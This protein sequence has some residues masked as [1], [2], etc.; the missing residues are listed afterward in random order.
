MK[1]ITVLS[2][3]GG[4]GKSSFTASFS[5]IMAN[6]HKV[7]A[8]DCDVDA[9]NLALVLGVEEENFQLMERVQ[10]SE[11]AK[12]IEEKCIQ[13]KECLNAC[14]F[15]SI[16]WDDGKNLPVI[17]KFICT[18]CGACTLACPENALKLESLESASIKVGETE[19]GFPIVSG[20]LDLGESGSGHV[21]NAV[22]I[23]SS[24]L[25]E[26]INAEFILLDS[27]AGIGCPVIASVRGSDYVILVTEPTPAAFWDLKRAID[28]VNHF[29]IPHGVLINRYDINYKF[30]GKIEEY[31]ASN[32]IPVIGKIAYNRK[33]VDALVNLKPVVVFEPKFADVFQEI[34]KRVYL[35]IEF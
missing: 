18:G 19:Y 14:N 8:V 5:V 25:A 31:F 30:T 12:L 34:L 20:Q 9:P 33:F 1:T 6:E 22:K 27:A 7:L 24:E 17:N 11:R 4:V 2:G 10:T 35:E 29:N 32:E 26:A 28:V 16:Q 23:W 13:H 21:V 3:K 15:S